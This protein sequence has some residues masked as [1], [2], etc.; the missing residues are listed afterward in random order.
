MVHYFLN[1]VIYEINTIFITYLH[2]ANYRD[3][4]RESA[5]H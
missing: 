4:A 1:E 3:A 2:Y 5:R